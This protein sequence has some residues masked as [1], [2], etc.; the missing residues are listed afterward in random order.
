MT[1]S[2][3]EIERLR[4]LPLFS[5]LSFDSLAELLGD[6]V[7]RVHGKRRTVFEQG[8]PVSHF[9][10]VLSGWIKLYRLR[11]DGTE[12]VMEIFGPG[13]SFAE[14]AMH[15]ADGYPAN[16]EMIEDGR[17]LEVP[18]KTFRNRM[19]Q[20]PDLALSMLASMAIRLKGFANRIETIK[21]Q[22]AAQRVADFLLK[23]SPAPDG[24]GP[25]VVVHLPYDK[26]LIANRLGMKPETFSRA[27][28]TLKKEGVLVDGVD[29]RIDDLHALK[30]FTAAE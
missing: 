8:D 5:G 13:E 7:V 1:I 21:S 26:Q 16:A 3:Y 24:D 11:P 22:S 28:S 15:M 30:R 18:T 23:F 6:A 12:V 4:V 27:L 19:Q 14:G 29:A 9:F 10:V 2:G 25:G 17:L 20:D